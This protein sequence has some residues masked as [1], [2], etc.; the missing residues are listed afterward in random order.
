MDDVDF[1]AKS[2]SLS[3]ITLEK[4]EQDEV[5]MGI[6]WNSDRYTDN[7]QKTTND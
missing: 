7:L 2:P 3:L 4:N 5:K 6:Q 1:G